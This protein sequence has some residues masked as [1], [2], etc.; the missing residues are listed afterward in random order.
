METMTFKIF[1]RKVMI[2][3]SKFLLVQ[4]SASF[5]AF[6]N[7]KMSKLRRLMQKLMVR[8]GCKKTSGGNVLKVG[9]YFSN[10]FKTKL[11]KELVSPA[12]KGN[13]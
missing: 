5:L 7:L 13:Y 6:T 2:F 11:W 10:I 3:V 1:A 8:I 4:T 9:S 12:K